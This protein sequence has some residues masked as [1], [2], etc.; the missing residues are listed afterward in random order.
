MFFSQVANITNG[1]DRRE[2]I[3][4][5]L[6]HLF[7]L[8]LLGD[9]LYWTDWQRRSID[10]VKVTGDGR[11]IIVDNLPNVMGLKAVRLGEVKGRN[12][13]TDNN[14]NCSH[15]CLNKPQNKYVCACQIGECY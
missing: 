15:L 2:V 7:G 5:N 11:Q 6:P 4:D 13:C 14:G 1:G 3:S 12:P 9:Y 10:R 8:S